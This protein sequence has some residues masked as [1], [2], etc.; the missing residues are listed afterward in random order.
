M[1]NRFSI[2]GNTE[3][4]MPS[5]HRPCDTDNVM[6]QGDGIF[7]DTATMVKLHSDN[8]GNFCSSAK[9]RRISSNADSREF[10]KIF[11]AAPSVPVNVPISKWIADTGTSFD[12]M[13]ARHVNEE[14]QPK[15]RDLGTPIEFNT[16]G[17]PVQADHYF[18]MKS[19]ALGSYIDALVLTDTP[20]VV[21]VGRRCM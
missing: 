16:A 12:L 4:E 1:H 19:K 9:F 3:L 11:I 13:D 2:L 8:G 7:D 21:S 17:G 14:L 15:G 20:N 18:R 5:G 6:S 10:G